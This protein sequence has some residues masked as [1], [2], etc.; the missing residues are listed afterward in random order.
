MYLCNHV[1]IVT[2][3]NKVNRNT[4]EYHISLEG[5]QIVICRTLFITIHS[6]TEKDLKSVQDQKNSGKL[7]G[8]IEEET[9][10]EKLD[11]CIYN[12]INKAYEIRHSHY[13]NMEYRYY[14]TSLTLM[15]IY[16]DFRLNHPKY[17]N[18]KYNYFANKF[19]ANDP[20]IHFKL[21]QID[22]CHKCEQLDLKIRNACNSEEKKLQKEEKEAHLKKANEFTLAFR[23]A[24][25]NCIEGAHIGTITFDYMKAIPIP[26]LPIPVPFKDCLYLSLF[27]I[28]NVKNGKTYFYLYHEAEANKGPNEVCTFI[29]HFC[30]NYLSEE[31]TEL[32]VFT[33]N[34]S[35]Q[36]KNHTLSGLFCAL[37]EI[38]RFSKI[39]H[40]YP[41]RGHS[42]LPCDRKF[43][44]IKN[45]LK[46][47]EW[48]YNLDE[49]N[50]HIRNS[51]SSFFVKD[52]KYRE[53]KNWK[54]WHDVYYCEAQS[55]SDPRKK[56]SFKGKYHFIYESED[57]GC[58]RACDNIYGES[59]TFKKRINE[60]KYIKWPVA[61]AYKNIK[62]IKKNKIDSL[63][64]TLPFVPNKDK[65]FYK[66]IIVYSERNSIVET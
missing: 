24:K 29:K 10:D 65:G 54:D 28:H 46:R 20:K 7:P 59:E 52:V 39:E 36:N 11:E 14:D 38:R 63:K 16:D 48:I 50:R 22:V 12:H 15:T 8:E 41:V 64:R 26:K 51:S 31:I 2:E 66:R 53:I 34:S 57:K 32:N 58:F 4:F 3:T 45:Y 56:F 43:G 13:A 18:V 6:I 60:D 55:T 23:K 33:D 19:Y 35:A 49:F 21:P 9:V 42:F 40:F 44:I 25:H 37:T 1:D 17:Q 30:D 62:C 61:R 47:H 27:C 5:R